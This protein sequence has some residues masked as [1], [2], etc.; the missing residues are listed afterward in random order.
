VIFY[1]FE[2]L[3]EVLLKPYN[4]THFEV[5]RDF[6]VLCYT[7]RSGVFRIAIRAGFLTDLG[8]IPK[9]AQ[10][11]SGITSR[12]N[13]YMTAAFI[14]HDILY[15]TQDH[16]HGYSKNFVDGLLKNMMHILPVNRGSLAQHIINLSV[17]IAG[18]GPWEELD[19]YDRIAIDEDLMY[20][21]WTDK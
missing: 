9:I 1:K 2:I 21:G 3:G 16:L 19:K 8:S 13:E 12:G 14:L 7:R 20:I 17:L 18:G 15:A 6:Y 5:A 4:D 10:S 11:I